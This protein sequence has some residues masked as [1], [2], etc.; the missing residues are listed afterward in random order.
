MPNQPISE[1]TEILPSGLRIPPL[2][3][4]EFVTDKWIAE[5]LQMSVATIRSQ[6]F[7]RRHGDEHWFNLDPV[8]I[9][10]KPRY[11]RKDVQAW[12]E[13][14]TDLNWSTAPASGSTEG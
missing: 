12:L 7:K 6:R 2:R 14:K 3:E 1:M 4:S 10:S 13:N 8:Y 11:R 9:G 5:Q